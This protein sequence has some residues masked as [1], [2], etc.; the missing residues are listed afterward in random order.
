MCRLFYFVFIFLPLKNYAQLITIEQAGAFA[1]ELV[2]N[3]FL[4]V[5]G[6]VIML[7]QLRNGAIE[8]DHP[9]TVKSVTYTSNAL[10]KE[11]I[12]QFCADALTTELGNRLTKKRMAIED[13]IS[14]K[15]P[16]DDS[17]G[18]TYNMMDFMGAKKGFV[19]RFA[20][21]GLDSDALSRRSSTLF[22][23]KAFIH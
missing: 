15:E 23:I 22:R 10:S 8:I 12:L 20:E 7:Q 9:S 11:T 6:K 13:K 1:D 16:I 18:R 4:T 14:P 21:R 3:E 5:E 19:S 2:K 17:L